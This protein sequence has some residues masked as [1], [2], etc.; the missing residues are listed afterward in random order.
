M[1][2]LKVGELASRTGLT[3]RTLHHYDE[4]GLLPP[5]RRTAAG[6][7]L[8]GADQVARLQQIVCLQ[9]LGFSLKEIGGLL[10]GS[11]TS[12][13]RVL[14][15]RIERLREQID[16]QRRLADRLQGIVERLD[17]RQGVSTEEFLRSIEAMTMFDR[18]FTEEQM[19]ALKE[20]RETLGEERIR[21]VEAEW[22]GLIA[23]VRAEMDRGTDP[24]SPEVRRLARRWKELVEEFTGG[25]AEIAA[26]V[27]RM[28]RNEESVRQRARIDSEMMEYVSRATAADDE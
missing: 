14:R 25:D 15:L 8:Y 20:R 6:H 21:Q 28:Y 26:S 18:Y 24:S 1:R 23:A 7:R 12:P 11:E 5:A 16:R 10:E 13:V 3:V 27:G 9:Q 2:Q 19:Q 17:S 4:I 22:P